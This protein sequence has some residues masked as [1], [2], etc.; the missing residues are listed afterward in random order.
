M[1]YVPYH[2]LG[3]RPN[4][5]VDG[6]GTDGTVLTLSHWPG[7]GTPP[8]LA[9]DLSTQIAF[10]YLETPSAH[11]SAEAVSNNH[12]DEDGICGVFTVLEPGEARA[13]RAL[14]IDVASAGD[15]STYASRN[16]ARIS[17]ALMAF[18]DSDRSPIASALAG[19]SYPDQVGIVM[20]ELLPR[21]TEMLDH[22]DRYEDLWKEEDARLSESEEAIA[23]GLVTIEEAPEFDL[24]IVTVPEAFGEVHPMAVYNRTSRH[25]IMTLQPHR[26]TVRYRYETWVTFVSRPV[27]PRVDLKPLARRLGEQD[28][29]TWTFDGIG[30]ITPTLRPAGDSSLAPERFR[31]VVESFLRSA[32]PE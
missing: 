8:E 2:E 24:A 10:R 29:T 30:H 15:F 26:C 32:R 5:V 20:T 11:V 25:R 21:L 1:K 4:I 7:S 14:L 17:M 13:R 23:R 31:D 3:G 16:A 28:S 9:A 22:P 18:E 27:M 19:R 6:E 12:F